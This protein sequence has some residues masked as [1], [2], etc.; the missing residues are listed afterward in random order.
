MTTCCQFLFEQCRG[1]MWQ[2]QDFDNLGFRVEG[3]LPNDSL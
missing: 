3:S 2:P 1:V